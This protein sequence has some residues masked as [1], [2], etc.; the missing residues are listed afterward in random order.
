MLAL[1]VAS[2]GLKAASA[3]TAIKVAVNYRIT[4]PR[5][6]MLLTV[7]TRVAIPIVFTLR[8][9]I[10]TNPFNIFLWL[11]VMRNTK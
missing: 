7:V 6:I 4:V 1:P 2:R 8:K 5:M 3:V 10:F 11:L 9:E